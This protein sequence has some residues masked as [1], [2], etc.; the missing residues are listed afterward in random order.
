M[1][2]RRW[3]L[4]RMQD[5]PACDF[6]ETTALLK[7]AQDDKLMTLP[8]QLRVIE[9]AYRVSAKRARALTI[10][11]VGQRLGEIAAAWGVANAN[12]TH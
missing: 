3:R 6:I 2:W 1:T 11:E 8:E 5:L 9:I 10:A 12:P 4:R 7:R